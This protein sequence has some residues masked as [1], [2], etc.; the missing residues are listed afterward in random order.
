[1]FLFSKMA[2]L[3][4]V[5]FT[6]NSAAIYAQELSQFRVPLDLGSKLNDCIKNTALQL[7]GPSMSYQWQLLCPLEQLTQEALKEKKPALTLL[8]LNQIQQEIVVMRNKMEAEV[9]AQKAKPKAFSNSLG[10]FSKFMDVSPSIEDKDSVRLPL[11]FEAKL[12][13]ETLMI[14]ENAVAL[15]ESLPSYLKWEG[16]AL[17]M[18]IFGESFRY[19]RLVELLDS[20]PELWKSQYFRDAFLPRAR[21]WLKLYPAQ[22]LAEW[23]KPKLAQIRE[24]PHRSAEQSNFDIWMA[25]FNVSTPQELTKELAELK[26]PIHKLFLFYPKTEHQRQLTEVLKHRGF[27]RSFYQFKESDLSFDEKMAYA[28]SLIRSVET[29]RA[30]KLLESFLK[31]DAKN[32][33]MS[34]R[35]DIFTTHIRLLRMKDERKH[36]PA[37]IERYMK[38]GQLNDPTLSPTDGLRV[39]LDR[40]ILLAKYHWTYGSAEV[41]QELIN[42]VVKRAQGSKDLGFVLGEASYLR[43]RIYEQ[44]QGTEKAKPFYEKAL[45]SRLSDLLLEDTLWRYLFLR[46]DLLGGDKIKA[47]KELP[48]LL[49]ILSKLETFVKSDRPEK[50]KWLYW[51][52]K[53]YEI[54]GKSVEARKNFIQ[55]YEQEPFSFYSNLSGLEL[56]QKYKIPSDW[57]QKGS[58]QWPEE[59]SWSRF[60]E[61]NGMLKDSA[62]EELAQTYFLLSVG[63]WYWA[64]RALVLLERQMYSFLLSKKRTEAEKRYFARAVAWM[65]L[66]IG[67]AMGALRAAELLRTVSKGTLVGE[68]ALYLYPRPY[69][70]DIQLFSKEKQMDPYLVI[71]LIRQESAFNPKAK[72]SANAMG[73]M[74]M[75]PPVAELEAT[76]ANIS[77]FQI[78]S[79]YSPT[80]ALRL[81]VQHLR[82]LID[83]FQDSWVPSI[84]SY[85]AGFEPMD[86][87]LKVY[88]SEY[89]AAFIERISYTE[90]RNY[91]KSILRNYI[92][93]Q[94]IYEEADV[95]LARLMKLPGDKIGGVIKDGANVVKQ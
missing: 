8:L 80:M 88:Q 89:P 75:I 23:L 4:L 20:Q 79:L 50:S 43:A 31:Q 13:Q 5:V 2:P 65:R 34:Q 95:D 40:E 94:R 18:G 76:K 84:G 3:C 53:S 62:F 82:S 77:N 81:G 22:T 49:S 10:I 24:V 90:T 14:V 6:V 78:D 21:A 29:E 70:G 66:S 44:N 83:R 41:A 33:S 17:L 37:L 42:D 61:K 51:R 25:Y 73:L 48:E 54:G 26:E 68:D 7:D 93:Y 69:W 9:L 86:K 52:A 58:S 35:W 57:K 64:E 59:P 27:A 36:I 72:S 67:D 38:W 85:N 92:N 55:S 63:E 87:W 28:A 16:N 56:G 12:Q 45:A 39:Q 91:V 74:Q 15:V 47:K 11:S 32:L 46:L 1:M 19:E 30:E 60:L 71:A